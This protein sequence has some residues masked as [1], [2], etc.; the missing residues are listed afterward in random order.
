VVYRGTSQGS[1]GFITSIT[2][3]ITSPQLYFYHPDHLGSSSLITDNN[4][5]LVQHLEY[6]PFGEVFVEENKST[7]STPYKFTSKELDAE[8]GLYYFGARY[9]DPKTSVWLSVDP[10][11][12]KY[13]NT[14]SYVYCHNNPSNRIDPDGKGDE[15]TSG[16]PSVTNLSDGVPTSAQSSVRTTDPQEKIKPIPYTP[17]PPPLGEIRDANKENLIKI[18]N[19]AMNDP[20][21]KQCLTDPALKAM[22]GGVLATGTAV[23]VP[24]IASVVTQL[25]KE[26]GLPILYKSAEIVM[27]NPEISQ[28]AIGA[29]IGIFTT[30]AT[31]ESQDVPQFTTGI[32]QIDNWNTRAQFFMTVGA[33]TQYV[34]SGGSQTQATDGSNASNKKLNK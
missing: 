13:I 19:E 5:T 1:A 9:Y 24:E 10:L 17:P 34:S 29:G 16:K 8:T 12:E 11:A 30:I 15:N 14:S 28:A 7:W 26:K 20:I 6:L 22:A 27:K 3:R 21:K 2:G 4:G 23:L 31:G 25:A 33:F 32:P 18:H